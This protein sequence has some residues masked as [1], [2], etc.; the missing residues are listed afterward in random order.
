[1]IE[2]PSAVV[3]DTNMTNRQHLEVVGSPVEIES[4]GVQLYA[5]GN[6]QKHTNPTERVGRVARVVRVEQERLGSV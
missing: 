4:D 3:T 1:V 2:V 6:L 5:R